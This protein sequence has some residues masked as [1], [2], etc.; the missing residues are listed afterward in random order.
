MVSKDLL[1]LF[2]KAIARE[3]QVSTSICGSMYY[4]KVFR[5]LQ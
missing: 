4:G 2:N 5:A 1:D 3:L